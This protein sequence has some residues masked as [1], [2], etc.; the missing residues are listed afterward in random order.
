MTGDWW[1]KYNSYPITNPRSP[2]AGVSP[3]PIANPLYSEI[4]P[5]NYTQLG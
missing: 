1:G 5:S 2:P 3:S 4:L